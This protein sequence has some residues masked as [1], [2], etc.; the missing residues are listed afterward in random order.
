MSL[1]GPRPEA[2]TLVDRYKQEIPLLRPASHGFT[3]HNRMGAIN[4]RYGNSIDDT[5][6]KLMLDFY[7]IKN[8][9]VVL[10]T[11]IFLKTVRTVLTGKGA[12]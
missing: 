10:D 9:G 4:Y 8:R 1:I 3:G 12:M 7:Y 5:I 2:A 6:Q 11:I